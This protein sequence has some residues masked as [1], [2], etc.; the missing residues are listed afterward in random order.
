VRLTLSPAAELAKIQCADCLKEITS[1]LLRTK[2]F[3]SASCDASFTLVADALSAK[4]LERGGKPI[5]FKVSKA[6]PSSPLAA[7]ASA[8]VAIATTT[9]AASAATAE[10][11]AFAMARMS[12]DVRKLK[13]AWAELSNA[14]AVLPAVFQALFLSSPMARMHSQRRETVAMDALVQSYLRNN[15]LAMCT[16]D[17]R[18]LCETTLALIS[19]LAVAL[20]ADALVLLHAGDLSVQAKV[21]NRAGTLADLV[22]DMA[23]GIRQVTEGSDVVV[24][25]VSSWD[26]RL[27]KPLAAKSSPDVAVGTAI[28]PPTS[29]NNGTV[30]EESGGGGDDAAKKKA[31]NANAAGKKK[32]GAAVSEAMAC[33]VAAIVGN[34]VRAA[35]VMDLASALCELAAEFVV[36]EEGAD[37]LT[38]LSAAPP[39]PPLDVTHPLFKERT[40]PFLVKEPVDLI[41]GFIPAF[42]PLPAGTEKP[43]LCLRDKMG[44]AP[45]A[46]QRKD[47]PAVLAKAGDKADAALLDAIQR[48]VADA[49][50]AAHQGGIPREL[51]GDK[52]AEKKPEEKKPKAKSAAAGGNGA[53][54]GGGGGTGGGGTGD[55]GG[56]VLC[57]C[58]K[59][60]TETAMSWLAREL[61][62]FE[63]AYA[64]QNF[65]VMRHSFKVDEAT[66]CLMDL[67]RCLT[68]SN[69]KEDVKELKSVRPD[70]K[71]LSMRVDVMNAAWLAWERAAPLCAKL[72]ENRLAKLCRVSDKA[73]ARAELAGALVLAVALASTTSLKLLNEFA[74][75]DQQEAAKK[76]AA[77]E[78]KERQRQAERLKKE[79]AE[80]DRKRRAEEEAEAQRA[81]ERAAEEE[82]SRR[83]QEEYEARMAREEAM[84]E[85][86]EEILRLRKVEAQALYNTRK[87]EAERRAEEARKGLEAL[88]LAARLAQMWRCELCTADNDGDRTTCHVCQTARSASL[89]ARLTNA[90]G[91][92]NCFLNVV[93]QSLWHVRPFAKFLASTPDGQLV[94]VHSPGTCLSCALQTTMRGMARG[95]LTSSSE[96]R[97]AF[98][99]CFADRFAL[100]EQEDASEAFESILTQLHKQRAASEA[101]EELCAC[102]SHATFGMSFVEGVRCLACLAAP[103]RTSPREKAMQLIPAAARNFSA[104]IRYVPALFLGGLDVADFED[105]NARLN[106][107]LDVEPVSCPKCDA[108][109]LDVSRVL[110][111]VPL[112][113]TVGVSWMS[114]VD[115]SAL[116]KS[117]LSAVAQWIDVVKVEGRVQR[118]M[119]GAPLAKLNAKLLGMM[120]FYGKHYAAFFKDTKRDVWLMFDDAAVREVGASWLE[121][122]R[123]CLTCK[124]QPVAIFYEIQEGAECKKEDYEAMAL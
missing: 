59:G 108:K 26:A 15:A 97:A 10:P 118:G 77:V 105:M 9:T 111:R 58:C 65:Y 55:D 56:A 98:S 39:P 99:A 57:T 73:A 18:A 6:L 85:R 82:R 83:K 74:A 90:I 46:R 78:E 51:L 116:I 3:T 20:Q 14:Y 110:F 91:E 27:K 102:V 42:T 71:V 31:A 36:I 68:S 25:L 94:H 47:A 12:D 13:S 117:V 122:A 88:A 76:K 34:T 7:N 8:A 61:R 75:K 95:E 45:Q 69:V 62:A 84:R 24:A 66:E 79:E 30:N 124:F 64:G 32:P 22:V 70:T 81:R 107:C 87:L 89:V 109:S 115:D 28:E 53:G 120:C 67:G 35:N 106:T 54:G 16:D 48:I 92:N 63:A 23:N 11:A 121:A 96:L 93:T 119:D 80:R 21:A 40:L 4:D 123:M 52:D 37:L 29:G 19:K 101:A 43:A 100:G 112:V 2:V 5:K 103:D 104:F 33:P 1:A 50:W 60:G 86:E 44:R 38:K 17:V 113:Y 114:G 41:I 49:K 72:E